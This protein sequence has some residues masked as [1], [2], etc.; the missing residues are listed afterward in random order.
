MA[1]F[2]RYK[3]QYK[4]K[5][6]SKYKS[7]YKL[8]TPISFSGVSEREYLGI[9]KFKWNAEGYTTHAYTQGYKIYTLVYRGISQSAHLCVPVQVCHCYHSMLYMCRH[10]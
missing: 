3:G 2:Q 10:I 7:R 4:S 8:Q 5:Y 6:K 9:T 1:T